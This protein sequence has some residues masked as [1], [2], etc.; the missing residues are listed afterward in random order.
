METALGILLFVMIVGSVWCIAQQFRKRR[1][2]TN[3]SG[4]GGGGGGGGT[5]GRRTEKF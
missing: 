1:N 3:A 4:G 5:N 2:G